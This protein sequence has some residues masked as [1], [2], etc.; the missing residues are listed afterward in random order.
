MSLRF[1]LLLPA[2]LLAVRVT[3]APQSCI[4]SVVPYVGLAPPGILV[5][6]LLLGDRRTLACSVCLELP[7][8]HLWPMSRHAS[9][10]LS[11][12]PTYHGSVWDTESI[13]AGNLLL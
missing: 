5:S 8:F 12:E 7:L 11:T 3:L 9:L 13:K 6:P 10:S 1:W 4:S 2:L